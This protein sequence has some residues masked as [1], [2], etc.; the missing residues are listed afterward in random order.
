MTEELSSPVLST[1]KATGSFVDNAISQSGKNL[2]LPQA[3]ARLNLSK[4]HGADCATIF[5][6]ILIQPILKTQSTWAFCREFLSA[7]S[8]GKQ[9]V[10]YRFLQREDIRWAALLRHCA[11]RFYQRHREAIGAASDCAFVVD[12]SLSHRCGKGVEGTASLW[13]H[14]EKRTVRAHRVLTLG[15]VFAKGFIPLASQ[16]C[17]G[18]KKT[19]LRTGGFRDGRSEVAR[20][21]QNGLKQSKFALLKSAL[22]TAI[23]NGLRAQWLIGDSAFGTKGNIALALDHDMDAL[24][25]MK[26]GRLKYRFQG[27][28]YVAKDFYRLFRRL[29]RPAAGGHFRCYDFEAEINLAEDRTQPEKWVKVQL[30]LSRPASNRNRGGWVLSLCT[31]RE[32]SVDRMIELYSMRWSIEV[33]FKESKQHL[34]HLTHQTGNFVSNYASI[35]LSAIRYL[36]LLDSALEVAAGGEVGLADIRNQQ[37]ERLTLIGYMGVL[38]QSFT[39]LIFGLLDEL[40]PR[41]GADII[42][43]IKATLAEK[44]D[45]FINLAF[46]ID[47]NCPDDETNP[48]PC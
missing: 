1:L 3:V 9:D 18:K 35:Q 34:G 15:F 33:F 44:L 20:A 17:I 6:A 37:R 25:L 8:I 28:D 4:K 32:V 5:F 47:F 2:R 16:L 36:L 46:Q 30:L 21:Y 39:R 22:K 14:N 24:F 41:L 43:E 29:M 10:I 12:D 7:F 19:C 23:A 26:R 38:W 11:K 27:R 13:D 48:Q 31:N 42:T 45:Q 40:E